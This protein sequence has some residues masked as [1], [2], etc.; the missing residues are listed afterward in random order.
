[1]RGYDDTALWSLNYELAKLT[2][3]GCR[4]MREE[5]H[6][7]P[8]EFSEEIGDGGGSEKWQDILL[9][10]E[11]GFQAW[12]DED[13]YFFDKPQEEAKFKEAMDLYAKWFGAL[14]D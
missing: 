9:R 7:Y 12:I 3:A 8:A 2:V 4:Y 10:I 6:G 1:M 5:G 14:W 11:E 13:G